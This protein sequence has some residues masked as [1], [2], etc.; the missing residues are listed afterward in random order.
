[1]VTDAAQ[2]EALCDRIALTGALG[3][4]REQALHYVAE[5]KAALADL[6]LGPS[7]RRALDLVADGV[8]E[9]YA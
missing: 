6:R 5:A 2:A 7:Q 4:A 8:V 1:V 3:E 9:R